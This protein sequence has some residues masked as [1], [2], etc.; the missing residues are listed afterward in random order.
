[1][2]NVASRIVKYGFY[3]VKNHARF[4]YSEGSDRMSS[5]GTKPGHLPVS[6]DCSAFVTLCY[7]WA[8]APDPNGLK[9]DHEGYCFSPDSKILRS[10][11]RW[12]RAGDLNVG[13]E[14]WG[15]EETPRGRRRTLERATVLASFESRKQCVR[16]HLD[17][18]ESFVCSDDHPW[19]S[20]RGSDAG[21]SY[22]EWVLARDLMTR[23]TPVRA[24]LPWDEDRSYDAGWLA[25]MFDGEGWVVRHGIRDFHPSAVGITQVLGS[26]ADRIETLAR[27]YGDFN[28]RVIERPDMQKRID[29]VSH[30][31]VSG[32]ARFLGQVRAERLIENFDMTGCELRRSYPCQIVKVEDVGEQTVQSIQTTSGTYFAEGFAVHNTGTLLSHDE[33][34]AL[35]R[36]NLKEVK[37]EEVLPGDLVVYGPGTGEHV[38]LVVAQGNGDPITISMGKQGDPSVVRV[39]QDGR[40]PQTYLR[41]DTSGPGVVR[42]ALKRLPRPHKPVSGKTRFI[43]P[44]SA[45]SG[46]VAPYV[47]PAP[48]TGGVGEAFVESVQDATAAI[49]ATL[50]AGGTQAQAQAAGEAAGAADPPKA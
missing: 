25:G 8:G 9:F 10:D 11:L 5:I 27:Q 2:A 17:S 18:G 34:I 14:L 40:T 48:G 19:L 22:H 38:A 3:G 26:T 20:S 43:D 28:L 45:S 15:F 1:M 24:F 49:K 33:H 21:N 47:V 16:V 12:V 13:D 39:S 50:A 36:T 35:F 4:T 29:M 37:V 31:G 44:P 41:C 42:R 30:G 6:C 32:A 7:F 23:P 46:H